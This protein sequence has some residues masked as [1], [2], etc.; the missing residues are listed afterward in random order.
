M[1]VIYLYCLIDVLIHGSFDMVH[2][3]SISTVKG[4]ASIGE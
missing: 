3:L 4:P 2:C 1:F